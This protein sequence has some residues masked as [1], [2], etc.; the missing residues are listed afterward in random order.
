MRMAT[1]G[2]SAS[3]RARSIARSRSCSGGTTSW[4]R[5]RSSASSAETMRLRM[6]KSIVFATPISCTRRNWPPSSG[7]R[8][9][10][11]VPLPSRASV[12][13]MRKSQES[14]SERPVWIATPLTAAMVSLSRLRTAQFRRC[15]IAGGP[16]TCRWGRCGRGRCR[17]R[18]RGR[19]R[20]RGP[21]GDVVAGGEGF[22][23]AGDDDDADAVVHLRL[24]KGLD[25]VALH[26][27]RHAVQSL[28]LVERHER[29]ARVVQRYFEAAKVAGLHAVAY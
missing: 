13:A 2:P 27:L 5:P 16:N 4:T 15:E 28:G 21:A 14:A 6:R 19:R 20:R 29:D 7:M 25:E 24:V 22:A 8:P 11:S 10:R 9:K 18:A 1:C 26:A 3:S 12:E 17:G 23:G